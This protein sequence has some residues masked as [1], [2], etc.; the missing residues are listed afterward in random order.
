MNS[1]IRTKIVPVILTLLAVSALNGCSKKIHITQ[2]PVFWDKAPKSVAVTPFRN[3][4][5]LQNIGMQVTSDLAAILTDN[6]SYTVADRTLLKAY[7]EE[8]DLQMAFSSDQQV[9]AAKPM[10]IGKAQA[11]LTGVV[12]TCN[13]PRTRREAK[14]VV[15]RFRNSNGTSYTRPVTQYVYTNEAELKAN[16]SLLRITSAGPKVI[17]TCTVRGYESS[18]GESPK[19][20][21][22]ACLARARQDVVQQLLEQFAVVKTVVKVKPDE[23]F[24][25]VTGQPYAGKWPKEK[26]FSLASGQKIILVVKLPPKCDRNTFRITVSRKKAHTDLLSFELPWK[27]EMS[28]NPAGKQIVIDPADLAAKGDG[29]GDYVI[30]LFSD[31]HPKPAIE[32]KIKILP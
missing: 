19:Y 24:F 10:E 29:P 30:R 22:Q 14:T 11:I 6:N 25:T 4:T 26:K 17:H 15:Q 32:H 12:T 28:A 20:S 5:Q 2:Y 8:H 1:A 7:L 31:G 16:A 18:S 13:W 23:T 21:R 27:R 9:A 3:E